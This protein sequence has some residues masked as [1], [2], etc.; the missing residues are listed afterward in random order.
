MY[1]GMV[2]EFNINLQTANVEAQYERWRHFHEVCID[3]GQNLGDPPNVA[4]WR[5]YYQ[6]PV[7][8]QAWIGSDTIQKRARLLNA[9]TKGG[10]FAGS[11]RILVNAIAYLQQFA[12]AGDPNEVVRQFV[13]YLLPKD[14]SS[15]QKTFMKSILLSNQAQ[16]HYWTDAWTAYVA[17]PGDPV[18]AGTV[19]DRLENLLNYITSMEEYQLC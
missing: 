8:Y 12:N 2:R 14:V 3:S 15:S 9:Y 19:K 7:Y 6:D 10:V 16:D 13:L 1:V 4:G 11:F 18:A 5:A 17:N